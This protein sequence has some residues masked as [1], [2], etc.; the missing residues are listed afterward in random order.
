[1]FPSVCFHRFRGSLGKQVYSSHTKR[2]IPNL[3]WSESGSV[4]FHYEMLD[5]FIGCWAEGDRCVTME[6]VVRNDVMEGAVG[7]VVPHCLWDGVNDDLLF[8]A[9]KVPDWPQSSL[10][11]RQACRATTNW[12]RDQILGRSVEDA[13]K[14]FKH[15]TPFQYVYKHLIYSLPPPS[16]RAELFLHFPEYADSE[17][18]QLPRPRP[19]HQYPS[20]CNHKHHCP[21]LSQ[22][23]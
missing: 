14:P 5:I 23:S 18:P 2:H 12:T 13:T 8:S 11:L 6:S 21:W 10:S 22:P 15:F 3:S 7:G 1:M 4:T 19:L 9:K 20:V 17:K 16:I